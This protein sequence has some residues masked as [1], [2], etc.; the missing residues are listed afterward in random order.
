MD[1][2]YQQAAEWI[3]TADALLIGAGAGMGVDS[4]LPD[5][6]GN[7]GFWQAYPKFKHL[8]LSFSDLANPVWFERDIHQAWGFYGHRYNLYQQTVPHAGFQILRQWAQQK[9]G[10]AF[11]YTS[12]V[13]GHF[14]KAGLDA[15]QVYECHGSINHLQCSTP[16][17]E[18]IWTADLGAIAIDETELKAKEPLPYCPECGTIA[19]PNILMFGDWHWI[20]QRTDRQAQRFQ[21]WLE[22]NRHQRIAIVEIGA[23][24]AVPTVRM[25]CEH[26]ARLSNAMLIRI[27]PRDT[28]A[29]NGT[30]IIAETGLVALQQL[31]AVIAGCDIGTLDS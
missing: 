7:Q 6:R 23:G 10:N 21:Q 22:P 14:Q 4:G 11:V 25:A 15:S 9:A 26:V 20:S 30:C 28:R 17:C 13:D 12:N 3:S 29:P 8:N 27:N 31:D 16:C 2:A 24:E 5:F 18:R 1:K 19:R